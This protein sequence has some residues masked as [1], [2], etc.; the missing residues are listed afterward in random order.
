MEK[1]AGLATSPSI[2]FHPEGWKILLTRTRTVG[3]FH[4]TV[5]QFA[6]A[7]G[8]FDAGVRFTERLG[9]DHAVR[10]ALR[11]DIGLDGIGAALGEAD[12][13]GGRTRTVRINRQNDLG[14][15]EVAV[16]RKDR[17]SSVS[18]KGVLVGVIF[19]GRRTIK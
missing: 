10:D 5:L 14:A 15:A 9:R 13:E 18:G 8:G 16:G 7:V 1:G 4:A 2:L 11:R 19:G 17:K 12:V 6:N 3:D